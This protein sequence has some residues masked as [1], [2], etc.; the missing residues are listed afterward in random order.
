MK[1]HEQK[2]YDVI[3]F[4]YEDDLWWNDSHRRRKKKRRRI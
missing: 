2:P 4:K 3:C 1:T